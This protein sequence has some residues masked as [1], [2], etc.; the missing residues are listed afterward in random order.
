MCAVAA[1]YNRLAF[2]KYVRA[3]GCP[4]NG[5]ETYHAITGGHEE[6]LQWAHANGCPLPDDA[7]NVAHRNGQNA[8]LRWLATNGCTCGGQFHF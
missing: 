2:I 7:C 4:W 8:I 3:R 6:L 1:V 5:L